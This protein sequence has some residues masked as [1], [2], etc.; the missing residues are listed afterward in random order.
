[1][2]LVETGAMQHLAGRI[3]PFAVPAEEYGDIGWR[4]EQTHTGR[5]EFLGGKPELIRHGHF[6]DVDMAMLIHTSSRTQ[7]VAGVGESNNGCVVKTIRYIGKAAHAGSSPHMGINALYAANIA[8]T[9]INALR[10]TF[11][12]GDTIRMHP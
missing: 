9:A 7:G 8:L 1:M 5:L 4:L 3:V 12:D 2:A 10:E 6:D 11:Q